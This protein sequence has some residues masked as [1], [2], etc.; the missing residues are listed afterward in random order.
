M[1]VRALLSEDGGGRF[2]EE[3]HVELWGIEP[4]R[5]RSDPVLS[6]R[7]DLVGNALDSYHFF[8]FGTPSVTQL[9]DGAIVVTEE[10]VTYVRCCRLR[11]ID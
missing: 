11:E 2:A 10:Y 5:V 9:S 8:T 4:A 7:R 3:D 1:G 6:K